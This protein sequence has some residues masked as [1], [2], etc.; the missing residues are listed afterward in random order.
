MNR[1]VS[2]ALSVKSDNCNKSENRKICCLCGKP[3]DNEHD[4]LAHSIADM[5]VVCLTS[6]MDY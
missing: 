3:I 5:C 2:P 4:L 6:V 1:L